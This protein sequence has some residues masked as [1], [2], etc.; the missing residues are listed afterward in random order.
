MT[1]RARSPSRC[2]VGVRWG[3]WWRRCSAPYCL[4]AAPPRR[5][6]TGRA[7][8]DAPTRATSIAGIAPA[9]AACS[10]GTCAAPA[11]TP[12][13]TGS[14]AAVPHLMAAPSARRSRAR[15]HAERTA[16]TRASSAPR[17][18]IPTA[19]R[20]ARSRVVAKTERSSAATLAP[21]AAAARAASVSPRRAARA[22]PAPARPATQ[23][24]VAA[25]AAT[26]GS[27]NA[28]R[29]PR[30]QP[31]WIALRAEGPHLLRLDVVLRR[32]ALLWGPDMRGEDEGM[33]WDGGFRPEFPEM[34]CSR[35]GL[36]QR[37]RVLRR[38]VLSPHPHVHEQRLCATVEALTEPL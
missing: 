20:T 15:T 35:S 5:L 6:R 10:T 7:T 18:S 17:P 36:S 24:R 22:G 9:P 37:V 27:T 16:A 11:P 4:A 30:Q 12:R 23:G 26:R 21:C 32:R 13:S 1:W 34:L 14:A 25:T 33:L 28:A 29:A 8:K 19:V 38:A 31:L 3:C 2:R